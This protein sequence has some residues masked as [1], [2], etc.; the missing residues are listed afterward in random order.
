MATRSEAESP[1]SEKE[2]PSG[3]RS[4]ADEPTVNRSSADVPGPIVFTRNST[5]PVSVSTSATEYARRRYG[6][7]R[8]GTSSITNCPGAVVRARSGAEKVAE[9]RDGAKVRVR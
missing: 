4:R 9:K 7:D 8:S 6:R 2:L 3:P 1:E 5:S